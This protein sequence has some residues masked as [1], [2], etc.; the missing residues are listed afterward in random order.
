MLA[1]PEQMAWSSRLA[2]KNFTP[3]A[4]QLKELPQSGSMAA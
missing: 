2:K 1:Q 4:L 3:C